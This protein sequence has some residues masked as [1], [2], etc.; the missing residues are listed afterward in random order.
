MRKILI[1][2]KIESQDFVFQY[3]CRTIERFNL[4]CFGHV[5]N[6]IVM[7]YGEIGKDYVRRVAHVDDGLIEH[8]GVA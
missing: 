7:E 1:F 2:P 4:K 8:H 3:H 6:T 5:M